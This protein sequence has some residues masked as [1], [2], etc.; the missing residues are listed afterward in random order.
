VARQ[1]ITALNLIARLHTLLI[2]TMAA[3]AAVLMVAVMITICLDVLI[4]N[5]D[6]QPSAHFFTF[7]EYALLLIPCLGAP[8]LVR[9]K[10]HVYVELLLMALGRPA[11]KWAI[12]LIGVISIAIC[13]TMAWYGFEVTMLDWVQNNKDVRSFDAPRWAIVM[14]IPVS[15]L[16]MGLEFVRYLWR[17]ESPLAAL[18]SESS[19]ASS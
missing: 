12:R 2:N 3:A 6:R 14:W 8:W 17:D 13:F 15:F 7:S 16:F 10:G 19:G 9:E 5:L 18:A 11:R 4:R 1:R